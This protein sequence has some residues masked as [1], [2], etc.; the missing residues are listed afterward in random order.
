MDTNPI[1]SFL[2]A[3]IDTSDTDPGPNYELLKW[4][5]TVLDLGLKY[6]TGKLQ[7]GIFNSH[8]VLPGVVAISFSSG[9][10]M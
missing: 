1:D 4:T 5:C 6:L 8:P 9:V 3:D 2:S 7:C 10:K